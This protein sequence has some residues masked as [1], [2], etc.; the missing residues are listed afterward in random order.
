MSSPELASSSR[1]RS[2]VPGEGCSQC[3]RGLDGWQAR[4]AHSEAGRDT[5]WCT[6]HPAPWHLLLLPSAHRLWGVERESEDGDRGT[7]GG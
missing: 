7:A 4:P 2:L 1:P 6:S 5:I 3:G